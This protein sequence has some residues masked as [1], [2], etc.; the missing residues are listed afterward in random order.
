MGIAAIALCG[1]AAAAILVTRGGSDWR[2]DTQLVLTR[3]KIGGSIPARCGRLE[4][5]EDRDHPDGRRISLKVLVLP[6]PQQ[7]AAGALFYLEGGPGGAATDSVRTVDELFG[8]INAHRDI[9]LVDQRGTGGS[10]AMACPQKHV[11]F[12]AA[13]RLAAYVRHCFAHLPGDPRFYTTA[14]A[15]DD[16]EDVR[17]ALDYDRIDLFGGS[18]GATLAQV[19][20]RL[21]PH[22]VRTMV[23][24]GASLLDVPVYERS[25]RNGEQALRNQLARCAAQQACHR[26]FPNTR[27][28]LDTLLSRPPRLAHPPGYAATALGPDAIAYTIQALL[29]IAGHSSRVPALVHDAA[30]GEYDLLAVEYVT[31]VGAQLDDRARLAMFWEILCSEPWARFDVAAMKGDSGGSYLARAATHHAGIFHRVCAGVPE[32][33]VP[34][35]SGEVPHSDVPVLFLAGADDPL[36]PPANVARRL[37]ALPNSRLVVVPGVGHGVVEYGCLPLVAA[38]FVEQGDARGL[39]AGCLRSFRPPPFATRP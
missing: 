30:R 38:R 32:G 2:R 3:C 13:A 22:S 14:V 11:P 29:Q 9:V 12:A 33:A 17:R 18:Y 5:P 34:E 24:D 19:Y 16:L 37:E 21:H 23:L 7:P 10:H 26:A 15:A 4:V 39:D 28:E 6:S 27:R 35:G 25:A 31:H 8:K 36:D 1:G 20:L